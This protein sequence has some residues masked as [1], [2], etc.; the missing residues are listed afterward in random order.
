MISIHFP[1]G[2]QIHVPPSSVVCLLARPGAKPVLVLSLAGRTH[3]VTLST[4]LLGARDAMKAGGNVS[5]LNEL[6]FR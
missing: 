5:A 1:N 6:N 2:E 4:S 3:E